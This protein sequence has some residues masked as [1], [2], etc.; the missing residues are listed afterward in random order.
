MH[1]T[2]IQEM[3]RLLTTE[4]EHTCLCKSTRELCTTSV[5]Q[6]KLKVLAM[7]PIN[8]WTLKIHFSGKVAWQTTIILRACVIMLL[9]NIRKQLTISKLLFIMQ[10]KRMIQPID[11][12]KKS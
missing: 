9:V 8:Q 6:S 5:L 4:V 11:D 3:V 7:E 1:V 12:K 10:E 2:L